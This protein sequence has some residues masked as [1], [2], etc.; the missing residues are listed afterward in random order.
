M[1]ERKID[2]L[3][4][5]VPFGLIVGLTVW[6][7]IQPAAANDQISKIRFFFGDTL[8]AF[9]IVMGVAVLIVSLFLA[10]SGYGSIVLGEPGEKPKY[11]FFTWGS[12]VF[13]CGL[14]ADILFYSFS[15]SFPNG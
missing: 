13:T 9:Y 15:E 5:L 1:K 8:G 3:L 6:L 14:A 11:S 4:T 10:F 7:F 2:W 12:M